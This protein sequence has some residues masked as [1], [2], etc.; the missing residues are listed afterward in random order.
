MG[1][2]FIIRGLVAPH[3]IFGS[4]FSLRSD[5]AIE[6]DKIA[7]LHGESRIG[8]IGHRT[9]LKSQGALDLAAPPWLGEGLFHTSKYSYP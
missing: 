5:R 7:H 9:F 2:G 3:P 6:Q 4:E 1:G 8:E